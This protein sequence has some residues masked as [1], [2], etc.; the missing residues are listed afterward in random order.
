M[1]G[2]VQEA[3]QAHS[4]RDGDLQ[5]SAVGHDHLL[6]GLARLA[7]EALDRL[8]DVQSLDHLAEHDVTL[9]QPRR[10]DR[11]HKEL[12]AVGVGT[13]VRH[14][15]D[16]GAGVLQREVLILELVAVD[17]L[18]SSAVVVGEVSA[19]AHEVRD[20]AVEDRS[21]VA[22]S[23]LAGA[24]GAEVLGRLRDDV[25]AQL[26]MEG[27]G[28]ENKLVE[29]NKL[30]RVDIAIKVDCEFP[31]PFYKSPT[32]YSGYVC[33]MDKITISIISPCGHVCGFITNT[34][35]SESD[36][37]SSHTRLDMRSFSAFY[38]IARGFVG[39]LPVTCKYGCGGE[40]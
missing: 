29:Y 27:R 14:G 31:L 34:L 20:D 36:N 13:G 1:D 10:L 2:V 30:L 12:R 19:L 9:V 24:Q 33:A 22:E 39:G 28:E 3:V 25:A 26:K 21:L 23:L 15:Q 16:S 40:N 4:L 35:K 17:G 18:A 6:G 8:D 32:S 37:S 11:A 5:G 7:A 38:L